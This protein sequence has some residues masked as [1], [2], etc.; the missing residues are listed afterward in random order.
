[1]DAVRADPGNEDLANI[2]ETMDARPSQRDLLAAERA[3][4]RGNDG[5][6]QSQ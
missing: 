5:A 3:P 2:D 4:D 1:M 6:G